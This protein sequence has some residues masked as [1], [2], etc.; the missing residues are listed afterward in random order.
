MSITGRY[1]WGVIAIFFAFILLHQIDKQ[2]INPLL[3]QVMEEFQI[4]KT[5]MGA[6]MTGSL[7]VST[8]LYPLWGFLYDR[9]SRARLLALAS[10]IWG[11][12]TWLSALARR[13][14]PFFVARASTG[15]DDSSYPG[16]YSLVADYFGPQMRSRIYGLLQLAQPLG[17]LSGMIL[18]LMVA[19][20]L[21][22]WRSVF[23]LTG[24]LGLLV[25]LVIFLFVREAP[26]GQAEPELEQ[27]EIG[28]YRFS[29]NALRDVLRKRTMWLLFLQGFFGVF[30]WNVI[31]VWF[32]TYLSQERGYDENA[33]LFTMAPLILMLSASYF[34]GGALGDFMFRRTPRGRVLVSSL[35]VIGGAFFL[36]LSLN[37][38]LEQRGLFFVLMM[39]TAFFMPF[40][41]PNVVSTVFDITLPEVRST[42]QA[43][44]YFIENTG[45]AFAPLLAGIIA[46]RYDLGTAILWIGVGA[47]LICFLIYLGA[48]FTIPE[49]IRSLRQQMALRSA[50]E[51]ARQMS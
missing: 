22:G 6:V 46:D 38:P 5:Q 4:S 36:L 48:L 25:A 28:Q 3:P 9:W 44:E 40:S 26:R 42:A 33:V 19:P 2:L 21:G 41:A 39:L 34:V 49:D 43:V 51:K 12:T 8:L 7:L 31:S 27:L 29:L 11:S 50:Q 35:G 1:R 20:M 10:F 47:W 30:P 17:Y 15:I 32:F 16:L 14:V 13:Y 23:Y 37:T 24:S 18:A 45:A